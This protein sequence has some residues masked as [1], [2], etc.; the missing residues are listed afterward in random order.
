MKPLMSLIFL[1][2][3][4]PQISLFSMAGKV[5]KIPSKPPARL[6]IQ[7]GEFLRYGRYK[8]GE[9]YGEMIFV[10][11]LTNRKDIGSCAVI[12]NETILLKGKRKLPTRYTDYGGYAVVTIVD[13]SLNE[14]LYS[15]PDNTNSKTAQS[16]NAVYYRNYKISRDEGTMEM[17]DRVWDG[18]EAKTKKSRAVLKPGY[19]VWDLFYGMIFGGRFLDLAKSGV[20][21]IA[22]PEVCKELV[23]MFYKA[24]KPETVVTPAGTFKTIHC[25]TMVADPFLGQLLDSF[26]R[27]AYVL[28]EDSDRHLAVR[29]HSAVGEDIELE[30]ISNVL[31]GR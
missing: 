27:E 4:L 16:E 10:T 13:G 22:I 30:E 15:I 2:L 14:L 5:E 19:P 28:I 20:T 29:M 12:Y 25:S 24:V 7:N 21:Q 26:M 1:V 18:Y 31:A 3:I 17:E 6:T 9:K 11:I 23:P 8:G